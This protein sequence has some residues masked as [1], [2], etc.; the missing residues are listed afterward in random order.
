MTKKFLLIVSLLLCFTTYAQEISGEYIRKDKFSGGEESTII[1]FSH[2]STFEEITNR[3]LGKTTIRK[4]NFKFK[5]DTLILNYQKPE[6]QEVVIKETKKINQNNASPELLT[7]LFINL[8]DREAKTKEDPNP[9]FKDDA[10]LH[11]KDINGFFLALPIQSNS[12]F[13]L[14]N[15][16]LKSIIVSSLENNDVQIDLEPLLGYSST[17]DIYLSPTKFEGM[18]PSK[19]KFLIENL[20]KGN[21][22]F[23]SI[24]KDVDDLVLEKIQ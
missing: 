20:E 22:K 24:G 17:I 23:I 7:N 6:R 2:D 4:G 18:T 12:A 11:F 19:Q 14:Y 16:Q 5:G 10:I 21:L 13:S 1:R 8:Y 9:H 3:N 15:D